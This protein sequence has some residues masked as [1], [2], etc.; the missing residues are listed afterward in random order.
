MNASILNCK[1]KFGFAAVH[2]VVSSKPN[3]LVTIPLHPEVYKL[4]LSLALKS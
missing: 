3:I 2:P 1:P 4:D